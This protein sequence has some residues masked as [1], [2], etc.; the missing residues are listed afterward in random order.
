MQMIMVLGDLIIL[1][2]ANYAFHLP[3]LKFYAY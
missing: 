2:L 1:A 3:P